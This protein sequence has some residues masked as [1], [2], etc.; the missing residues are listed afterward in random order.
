MAAKTGRELPTAWDI[1]LA[2]TTEQQQ[3]MQ[4]LYAKFGYSPRNKWSRTWLIP[5]SNKRPPGALLH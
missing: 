5:R 2:G 4:E 3:A 1:L